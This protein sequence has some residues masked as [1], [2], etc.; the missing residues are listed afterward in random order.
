[1]LSQKNTIPWIEKY[2]PKSLEEICSNANI[3]KTLKEYTKRKYLP[4]M[5]F[6]GP[7]GTGKT[8][9]IV[10]SAKNIY[11]DNYDFMVLQINASEERGIEVVRN[12][13][14]DF[15]SVK[16]Y[17]FDMKDDIFKL[18]IL[19]EADSMTHDAQSMLRRLIEDNTLNAR[20]C[21]LC[22][23]I[24]NVDPAIQSR[25]TGFRFAPLKESDIKDR[26][27]YVAK[28]E[29]IKVT[30]SGIDFIIKIAKGDMRKVLNILQTSSMSYKIVDD[31][32][33]GDT[34]SYP[35][36]S[37]IEK[38]FEILIS[39][40]CSDAIAKI[41]KIKNDNGYS[42]LEILSELH[43]YILRNF[44]MSKKEDIITSK[45]IMETFIQ[46]KDIE[47]NFIQCPNEDIQLGGIVGIF[48]LYF[49]D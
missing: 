47:M 45:K 19:D 25:C 2:R 24:K 43:D 26:I 30:Q 21:L 9:A 44:V 35:K 36:T 6:Y 46:L 11:G 27:K 33:V 38:I 29:N 31:N 34:T 13:I 48:C 16:N 4:H 42:I 41:K 28:E 40:N 5:L 22:N 3:I 20:F 1:M 7:P 10:S 23:N 32:A 12:K 49:R 18:V 39:D 8:S 17:F 15:V 14:K 37:N